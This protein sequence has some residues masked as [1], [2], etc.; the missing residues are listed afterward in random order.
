M[1]R[2]FG[3]CLLLCALAACIPPSP[4]RVSGIPA[5]PVA[6]ANQTV[7]DEQA[8]LAVELAYK[9]ARTAAELAVD[10]GLLEGPAAA[11]VAELDNKAFR[12]V[13]VVRSAYA[14]GNAGSYGEALSE[15][16]A[17]TAELL[18]LVGRN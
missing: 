4:G 10:T 7:L 15:A 11:R 14:T 17:A 18:A 16:R 5:S 2:F 13:A 1:N 9:A 6:A 12:A 3:V 8:M